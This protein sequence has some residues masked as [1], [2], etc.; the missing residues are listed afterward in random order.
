MFRRLVAILSFLKYLIFCYFWALLFKILLSLLGVIKK[1]SAKSL[2]FL[3]RSL[4]C[5]GGG[6]CYNKYALQDEESFTT[7]EIYY[8]DNNNED[9]Y[10]SFADDGE[11]LLSPAEKK[12][13]PNMNTSPSHTAAY[14]SEETGKALFRYRRNGNKSDFRKLTL[15]RAIQP[16][17][18]QQQQELS[19]HHQ[20]P[21][22]FQTTIPSSLSPEVIITEAQL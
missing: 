18:E 13:S 10:D 14:H 16:D 2:E 1:G 17:N 21:Y 15:P 19:C 22:S 12:V 4:M 6:A 5:S 9:G 3:V 20:Q 11:E 7:Q 8:K